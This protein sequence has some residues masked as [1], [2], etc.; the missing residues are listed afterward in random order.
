M[1][2]GGGLS[3][4]TTLGQDEADGSKALAVCDLGKDL[5]SLKNNPAELESDA[6]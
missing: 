5:E 4:Q 1:T 6:T 3:N 2:L